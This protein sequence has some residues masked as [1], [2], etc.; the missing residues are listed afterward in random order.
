MTF[1][2]PTSAPLLQHHLIGFSLPPGYLNAPP[3]AA[4]EPFT[5]IWGDAGA[6]LPQLR[7][8]GVDSIELRMI[9]PGADV[10]ATASAIAK[11]FDNGFRLTLHG[12]LP[13]EGCAAS[14]PVGFPLWGVADQV[15]ERQGETMVTVH[16]RFSRDLDASV[17]T[18]L[19]RT[20][21]DLKALAEETRR[22]RAPYRYALEISKFKKKV[23]PSFTWEG[24]AEMV[25][26]VD[27]PLVGICW[28]FGHAFFNVKA[29][30]IDPTPPAA[31][32][33]RV[34]HTHIHDLGPTGQTHWPLT[35]G[36][37]PLADYCRLLRESNYCGVFNLEPEPGRYAEEAEI[38]ERLFQSVA[39]LAEQKGSW[40]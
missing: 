14:D 32:V 27:D 18:L 38:G 29:G 31:F 8:K 2:S 16:A 23:D 11:V 10:A 24:V 28:D 37:L 33:E 12:L 3:G 25:A 6:A 26:R 19:A 17:D 35:E 21:D 40:Q 15:R 1:S 36:R 5:G 4:C 20:V 13:A 7:E 9:G 34:V 39:L 22:Q 30:L